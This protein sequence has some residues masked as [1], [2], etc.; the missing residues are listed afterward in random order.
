MPLRVSA[1]NR[2]SPAACPAAPGAR[3]EP[4]A[5]VTEPPAESPIR[6]APPSLAP[7]ATVVAVRPKVPFRRKV[8]AL[9]LVAPVWLPGPFQVRVPVPVLVRTVAD[10]LAESVELVLLV[11]EPSKVVLRFRA[12]IE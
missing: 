1:A 12:P 8:P 9:I 5:A 7:L 2:S 6:P 4:L 3:E 11:M 10:P